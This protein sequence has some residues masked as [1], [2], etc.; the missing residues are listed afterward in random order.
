MEGG[1]GKGCAGWFPRLMTCSDWERRFHFQEEQ[2]SPESQ[3]QGVLR[4][5]VQ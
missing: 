3:E 4:M 5:G 2:T 1:L